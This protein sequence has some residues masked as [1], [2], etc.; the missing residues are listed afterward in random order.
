MATKA[1]SLPSVMRSEVFAAVLLA[2]A[3]NVDA[4]YLPGSAPHNYQEGDQVDLFV[5]ALTPMLSGKDDA[6]LVRITSSL[7]VSGLNSP[8]EI[9]HKL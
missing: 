5:N 1:I 6:K 2:V 3:G 7:P 9:P 4:F 8:L